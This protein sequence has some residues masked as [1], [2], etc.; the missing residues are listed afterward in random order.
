V[1]VLS[2]LREDHEAIITPE[3]T[4]RARSER[5]LVKKSFLKESAR[6][7]ND[8]WSCRSNVMSSGSCILME[9]GDVDHDGFASNVGKR[10]VAPSFWLFSVYFS[11]RG[12]VSSI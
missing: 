3:N 8:G 9:S 1:V 12:A 10:A 6:N 7:T 2:E 4:D 11:V 5:L